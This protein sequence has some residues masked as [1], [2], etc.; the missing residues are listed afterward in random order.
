MAPKAK[1]DATSSSVVAV[2]SRMGGVSPKEAL[3]LGKGLQM[4]FAII[5]N[6]KRHNLL[7]SF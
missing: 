5:M 1:I 7:T 3:I 6:T 2:E 4:A